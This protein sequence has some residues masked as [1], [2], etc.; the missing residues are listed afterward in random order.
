MNNSKIDDIIKDV[1]A[2]LYRAEKIYAEMSTYHHGESVIR[3]EF[4]EFNET[5]RAVKQTRQHS[6]TSEEKS[7]MYGELIQI[8]AMCIRFIHDLL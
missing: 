6:G 5:V 4:D 2:E 3:E 8:I 1:K 7:K